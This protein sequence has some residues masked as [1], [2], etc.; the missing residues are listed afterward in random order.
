MGCA[1]D[2]SSDQGKTFD[3]KLFQES[4]HSATPYRPSSNG[5]VE[6]MN[7][8]ILNK[9]RIHIDGDQSIW[10]RYLPFIGLAIR[11]TVNRSTGFTPSMPMLGR[12]VTLWTC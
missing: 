8:E 4:K 3:S 5:Q 1:K 10:D 2:V 6:R 12:E 11:A 7:R 9:L